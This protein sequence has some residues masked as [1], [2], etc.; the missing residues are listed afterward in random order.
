MI[1]PQV[2]IAVKPCANGILAAL[3]HW[4]FEFL[5][6]VVEMGLYKGRDV[7]MKNCELAGFGREIAPEAY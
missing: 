1:L 2:P 7:V 3:A 5:L 4:V 6:V